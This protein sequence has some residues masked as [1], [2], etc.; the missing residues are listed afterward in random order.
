M[1]DSRSSL[2]ELIHAKQRRLGVEM[3]DVESEREL[4]DTPENYQS[5]V[6]AMAEL[7]RLEA[8]RTTMRMRRMY[9]ARRDA[10]VEYLPYLVDLTSTTPSP[11]DNER[12]QA[13]RARWKSMRLA[14]LACRFGVDPQLDEAVMADAVR[15]K[16]SEWCG[17]A[18]D[19]Q[20]FDVQH[21][22]R[23][24]GSAPIRRR[25]R[26]FGRLA[27]GR[28]VA[29]DVDGAPSYLY[30]AVPA[31]RTRR[32]TKPVLEGLV[33]EMNEGLVWRLRP[34]T[35]VG[36]RRTGCKCRYRKP[37][38]RPSFE[39]CVCSI[40]R[41]VKAV[42]LDITTV[43]GR[44]IVG[45]HPSEQLFLKLEVS[46]P[47]LLRACVGWLRKQAKDRSN[48]C[49][50]VAVHEGTI[51]PTVRFMVDTDLVGCGWLT[52]RNAR[53]ATQPQT[54]CDVECATTVADI[55]AQ[56]D[57]TDNAPFRI[58]ALDI[59]CMSLDV[60]VFPTANKCPVIQM[61]THLRIYG[62]ADRDEKKVFCLLDTDNCLPD[63]AAIVSAPHET[64]LFHEIFK[65]IVEVD[66]DII[67]GQVDTLHSTRAAPPS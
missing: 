20:C 6:E 46:Y 10:M 23:D 17:K 66:P 48:L 29:V 40:E 58:L 39:P 53:L 15:S 64:A 62:Q 27:N 63:G 61:S 11:A 16:R 65:Y 45:Y 38:E 36:C 43:R 14:K 1:P 21:Y 19:M 9:A 34:N 7:K 13:T 54:R 4:S 57:R 22:Y 8:E 25:F 24:V 2:I 52:V 44:S 67:T 5:L 49:Y 3:V 42:V 59:E 33:D 28:S 37:G 60:N 30:A 56:S 26:I 35:F 41:K 50:G 31:D 32:F 55:T 18:F 12:V 51:D 47:F